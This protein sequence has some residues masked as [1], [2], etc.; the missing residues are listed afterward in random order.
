MEEKTCSKCGKGDL[1]IYYYRGKNYC[2]ECFRP[3]KDTVD[4]ADLADSRPLK[5]DDFVFLPGVDEETR[6]VMLDWVV[7]NPF[8]SIGRPEVAYAFLK[9]H[10][11]HPDLTDSFRKA[12]GEPPLTTEKRARFSNKELQAWNKA[13]KEYLTWKTQK[14]QES[15]V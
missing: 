10:F 2:H 12:Q 7:A 8:I 4:E 1:I 6:G 3:I 14:G 9:C 11:M 5:D 13:A 15:S